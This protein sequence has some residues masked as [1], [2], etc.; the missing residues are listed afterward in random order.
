[1]GLAK[2]IVKD[3]VLMLSRFIR[4]ES[5]KN[6]LNRNIFVVNYHSIQGL[7]VDPYINKE[8]YRTESEF[9]NDIKFYQKH[10]DIISAVDLID[11]VK[12]AKVSRKD[13]LIL[14]F[15][16]G[17]RINNEV[18]IPILRRYD[19]KATLFLNSAFVDNKDLHFA[20]KRNLILQN[21]HDDNVFKVRDYLI[22]HSKF[23][24]SVGKSLNLIGYREKKHFDEI[25]KILELDLVHYLSSYKPYL[26]SREIN[27]ILKQGFSVGAHS[28]DHPRY[29]E[30][31]I[32]EQVRQT[33]ESIEAIVGMFDLPY[34]LYAFPYEDV[35]LT[36][37]FYKRIRP[38]VDLTFGTKGFIDDVID[39]NIQRSEVESTQLPIELALKYRF[40][41]SYVYTVFRHKKITRL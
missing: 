9:E 5:L 33:V 6:L 10:F 11:I 4:F 8:I 36:K 7:D 30:L 24:E 37:E 35:F 14:T 38:Y 2:K 29:I 39:F 34:R 16:D 23:H 18:H 41:S 3:G 15:D 25:A 40:F 21:I 32:E 31:S 20:R 27:N 13:Y 28:V 19:V 12:K 22:D 26:S 1:M 17:L